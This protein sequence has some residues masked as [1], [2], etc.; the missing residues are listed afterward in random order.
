MDRD[1]RE[2]RLWA[3]LLGVGAGVAALLLARQVADFVADAH[4]PAMQQNDA[5]AVVGSVVMLA[6]VAV[7]AARRFLP[8]RPASGARASRPRTKR[9]TL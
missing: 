5:I 1:R 6:I 7:V 2:D 4:R 9:G 8:A 3:G